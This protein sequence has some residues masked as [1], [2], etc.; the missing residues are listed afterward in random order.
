MV[1]VKIMLST[2]W[3]SQGHSERQD[4]LK[5]ISELTKESP[6]ASITTHFHTTLLWRTLALSIFKVKE[7]PVV[8]EVSLLFPPDFKYISPII[9]SS[10]CFGKNNIERSSVK[11]TQMD[12]LHTH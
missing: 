4:R 6:N 9:D 11:T 5:V 3:K 2:S 7:S 12:T 10:H 8:D 1:A